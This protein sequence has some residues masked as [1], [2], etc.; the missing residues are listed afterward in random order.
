MVPNSWNL[1]QRSFSKKNS[2]ECKRQSAAVDVPCSN[3]LFNPN[4][5]ELKSSSYQSQR[6][7]VS[8][9]IHRATVLQKKPVVINLKRNADTLQSNR[10]LDISGPCRVHVLPAMVPN[11]TLKINSLMKIGVRDDVVVKRN[12]KRKS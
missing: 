4:P 10:A 8:G 11:K 6:S 12:L 7:T 2:T 1:T 5:A 3:V 9:H